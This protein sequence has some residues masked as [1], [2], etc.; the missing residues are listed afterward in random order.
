MNISDFILTQWRT[1]RQTKHTP[2]GWESADAPCCINRGYTVDKRK[3]G[4]MIQS[5]DGGINYSCF[6]CGFK[7]GY[8]PKHKL[9]SRMQDLLSWMGVDDETLKTIRFQAIREYLGG[10]ANIQTDKIV[11]LPTLLTKP[12]PNKS[13]LL[14]EAVIQYPESKAVLDYVLS[15]NLSLDDYPYYWS[16]EMK[17]RFIIPYFYQHRIVGNTARRIT[18]GKPKYISEQVPG[19]V[20]NLDAQTYDRKFVIVVEGQL[21][22]IAIG[23]VA[24]MSADIMEQQALFINRLN[25]RVILVPDRDAAGSRT[26][27][28]AIQHNW[29]VSMPPNWDHTIKDVQDA[30]KKYGKLYTLYSIIQAADKYEA[31]IKV[32]AKTWFK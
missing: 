11:A 31:R 2:S 13:L 8:H 23:G 7:T 17:D 20:F 24:I 12:L 25:R 28:A 14:Q 4:G 3:R 19:Y 27:E 30:V 6:N 21:D 5:D 22:A 29:E 32:K 1:T 18:E 16:P 10:E 15:R 26:V 9:S